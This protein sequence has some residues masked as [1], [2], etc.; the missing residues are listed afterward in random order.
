[1]TVS[2]LKAELQDVN[3]QER[4]AYHARVVGLLVAAEVERRSADGRAAS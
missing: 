2:L 4:P 1:M 3:P